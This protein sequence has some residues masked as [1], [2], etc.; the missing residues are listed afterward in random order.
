MADDFGYVW[1]TV[2]LY[3]PSAPTFLAR[4]WVNVA[5]KQ[6][7]AARRWGFMR[8]E[9]TLTI[10]DSDVDVTM[11]ADFASF[12]VVVDPSRQVRISFNSSLDDLTRADPALT[13]GGPV[14][15]LV[16]AAPSTV[17]ATLGRPRYL[18]YPHGSA[19]TL[20]V[21]YNTQGSRLDEGSPAFPGVLADAGDILVGGALAQAAQ[22]PGTPDKPNPYFNATLGQTKR[23]EFLERVQALSL[24]DDEQYPDDLWDAWPYASVGVTRDLRAT[25]ATVDALW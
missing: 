20:T 11:P 14:C 15:A 25:D 19:T 4:E 7:L 16:A 13:A 2:R 3:V 6:L 8:G 21:V 10:A 17:L 18:L 24:R 22:W 1:R 23:A 5:W 12:R 9:T